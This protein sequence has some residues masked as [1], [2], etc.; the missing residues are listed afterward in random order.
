MKIYLA[1][2]DVFLPDAVEIGRRKV[3]LC[4]P[5]RADRTVSAGQR[6]RS[7]SPRCLAADLPR[8][9]GHDGRSGRHHRQ[10]D[11]V[12]RAAAPTP[13]PSTNSATWRARQAL[14]RLFQRSRRLCRPRARN[15]PTVTSADG[16]LT[17]AQGLTV[18]DF[19]L[20]DNLMMI[21]ALDLH[22]C[23]LVTPRQ[24]PRGYLARSDRVR[25][26]R[27]ISAAERLASSSA[28]GRRV[29]LGQRDPTTRPLP[30]SARTWCWSSAACSK[31][32]RER[33]PRSKPASSP[34]TTSRSRRPPK[35][36]PP[37]P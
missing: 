30:A 1:G 18:E 21:H 32:G 34:P 4:A 28:R 3:E 11:A 16:H 14:P 2:P 9:R 22:G 25:D 35:T 19:G 10:S 20:N 5:S 12:S 15:S 13:E 26:L 29:E 37:M 36:L 33:R 17:D 27:A 8:Q 7:C 31:A 6:R 24:A 23:A